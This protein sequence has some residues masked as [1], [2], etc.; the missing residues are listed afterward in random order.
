MF[1]A[2][3]NSCCTLKVNIDDSTIDNSRFLSV[4][5]PAVSLSDRSN[6]PRGTEKKYLSKIYIRN[7]RVNETFLS[8]IALEI[9]CI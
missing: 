2:V 9:S 6:V 8:F 1:S 3:E 7:T 4:E 5:K